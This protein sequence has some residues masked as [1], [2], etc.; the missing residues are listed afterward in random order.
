MSFEEKCWTPVSM[1]KVVLAWL[2]AERETRLAGLLGH[3]PEWPAITQLLLQP[4]LNNSEQN[5]QRLRVLYLVRNIFV[6]EIPADTEWYEVR[7]LTDDDLSHLYVVNYHE[8]KDKGDRNELDKVAAR[9]NE[10][11]K[12]LPELWESPI[13]WGHE[14]EG[15]FTIIEGNNRLTAYRHS[16]ECGLNIPILIGLSSLR[17][18]WHILDNDPPPLLYDLW[19]LS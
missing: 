12:H 16:G 15:P 10:P 11:L 1:H 2:R 14:R 6:G 5:R 13:L 7:N 17:C 3:L 8:W 9:I 19:K 4:D 18:Y